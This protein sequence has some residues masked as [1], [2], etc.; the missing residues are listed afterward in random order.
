MHQ[1]EKDKNKIFEEL[2]EKTLG[3]IKIKDVNL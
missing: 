1:K 2:I 3:I